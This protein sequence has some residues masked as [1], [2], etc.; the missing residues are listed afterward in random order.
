MMAE[1]NE[2]Y[3]HLEEVV[4]DIRKVNADTIKYAKELQIVF[5]NL[6]IESAYIKEANGIAV[7]AEELKRILDKMVDANTQL[8]SNDREK[9]NV[10]MEQLKEILK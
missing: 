10:T 5:F 4:A 9:L 6:E 8:V 7:I 3:K 2:I 1:Q